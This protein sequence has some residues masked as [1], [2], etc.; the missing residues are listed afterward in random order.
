MTISQDAA[1]PL[2]VIVGATGAQGSSVIKALEESDRPYRMRGFT[3][4]TS[5]PEAVE[6]VKRGVEM[7]DMD[8]NPTQENK[9]RV[10]KAF[11]GATYVFAVT[12]P[13]VTTN[14]EREVSEGQMFVD[15]A[16]AAKVELFVWSGLENFSE[17]S[18]GK[19][20]HADHFD[21][22]A[23]V[24][25]YC[26]D[27]GIPFV[28]VEA[29][30]YMQNYLAHE[31]PRKQ[32]DGF[33][34]ISAPRSS[35]GVAHL[36]DTNCDYGLWVRKAI[37]EWPGGESELL[38]CADTLTPAELVSILSDITRKTVKFVPLTNEQF[39]GRAIASGRS[40]HAAMAMLDMFRSADEFGC[41][42]CAR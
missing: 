24:T 1:A 12:V 11:E 25:Q 26:R 7:V 23:E 19:Y 14:K 36:I 4:S 10:S 37:E 32:P 31:A 6:L 29:A 22:K 5:K 41:E 16:K 13:A 3:R 8:V 34:V 40:E 18:G 42:R 27:I 9:Q 39:I 30:G 33:F 20:I 28:N 17:V 35:E 38:A 15:A 21:G 2:I